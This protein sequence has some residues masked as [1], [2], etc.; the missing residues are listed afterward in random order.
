MILHFPSPSVAAWWVG[1]CVS[2]PRARRSPLSS[3]PRAVLPFGALS[4]YKDFGLPSSVSWPFILTTRI[5]ESLPDGFSPLCMDNPSVEWALIPISLSKPP[6][7]PP[8]PSSRLCNAN[9]IQCWF[10][11]AFLWF[12][13]QC[14]QEV[15]SWALFSS[16]C[17]AAAWP[18]PAQ[19]HLTSYLALQH[20]WCQ[21]L[22]FFLLALRWLQCR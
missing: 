7:T 19:A 12:M 1:W 20:F 13:N 4:L 18:P 2:F 22:C 17:E 5:E 10:S 11:A 3:Y 15:L 9:N 21:F 8:L 16:P 14:Q 6:S